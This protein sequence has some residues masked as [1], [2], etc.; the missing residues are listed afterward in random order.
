MAVFAESVFQCCDPSLRQKRA[1]H[2]GSCAWKLS[3]R[4]EVLVGL[5]GRGKSFISRKLDGLGS[6]ECIR[7]GGGVARVRIGVRLLLAGVSI[8]A[9]QVMQAKGGAPDPRAPTP[10]AATCPLISGSSILSAMTGPNTA[11][12]SQPYTSGP[13]AAD[14][15]WEQ[16]DWIRIG[17][18]WRWL[19]CL[20]YHCDVLRG[21]LGHLDWRRQRGIGSVP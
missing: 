9:S 12:A 2:P 4:Y 11:P 17:A 14:D 5:P 13:S 10:R 18:L 3:P 6:I 15:V 19:L 16:H 8:G 20:V 7:G 1:V 21:P